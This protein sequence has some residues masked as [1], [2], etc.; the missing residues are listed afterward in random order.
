MVT[1]FNICVGWGEVKK[2]TVPEVFYVT[3]TLQRWSHPKGFFIPILQNRVLSFREVRETCPILH[4]KLA[5]CFNKHLFG[6]HL[7]PDTEAQAG[8]SVT[9]EIFP[10][11]SI[12]RLSSYGISPYN[13][14]SLPG[15]PVVVYKIR[16][17]I[18]S[19]QSQVRCLAGRNQR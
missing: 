11:S 19:S 17:L 10:L 9:N 6:N 1:V 7:V 15:L 18:L 12:W 14:F 3:G 13:T 16:W 8:E 4:S 2:P 5:N